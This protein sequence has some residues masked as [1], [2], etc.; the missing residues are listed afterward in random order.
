MKVIKGGK[1]EGKLDKKP[2]RY[3]NDWE[4][5]END[6]LT[7]T[8]TVSAIARKHG[9]SETAIRKY[10]KKE[11]IE[12]D[13]SL[14]VKAAV[15]NKLV[16]DPVRKKKQVRDKLK[17]KIEPQ[18]KPKKQTEKEIVEAAAEESVSF[19]KTWDE[20]FLKTITT[21]NR[22]KKEIFK[23][24]QVHVA[25]KEGKAGKPDERARTVL[26]DKLKSSEK[27]SVFN[28]VVKAETSVFEAMRKNLGIGEG[29]NDP[30]RD[31]ELSNMND[32]ELRREI[33]ALEANAKKRRA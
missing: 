8:R 16:R 21:A 19:I 17:S 20:I 22:L 28:S 29:E 6:L 26:V 18:T 1:N 3:D 31:S 33:E 12:R 15:R 32:D 25:A 7:T 4:A 23:T 27:A 30:L 13:L 24:V 5:I 11:S 10:I 9:L 14:K 2:K